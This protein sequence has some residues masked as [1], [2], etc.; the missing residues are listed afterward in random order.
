M[1]KTNQQCSPDRIS[2][3]PESIR[4]D[5]VSFL[6]MVDAIRTSIL[7]KS[8]R[9][10]C[11]SLSN[12][13][14][15]QQLF[16][17]MSGKKTSFKE[18]VNQ[19]IGCRDGSSINSFKLVVDV[20][21]STVP[22]IH[23][24]ISYVVQ[25]NV[26]KLH[27]C[28]KLN[29]GSLASL[30]CSLFACRTLTV[31]SLT[32]IHLELPAVVQF[33]LLKL[34]DLQLINWSD[35]EQTNRLISSCPLI[36][37]LSLVSCSWNKLSILVISAP[38][39][40]SLVLQ[41]IPPPEEVRISCPNLYEIQYT[42]PPPDISA[43][44]L[45]SL[46]CADLNLV[47]SWDKLNRLSETNIPRVTKIFM[48]MQNVVHL[49]LARFSLELL[50]GNLDLLSK[51]TT[52]SCS[53]KKLDLTVFSA[54][55]QVQFVASLLIIFPNL[56]ALT[57]RFRDEGPFILVLGEYCQPQK[58]SDLGALEII[59]IENLKGSDNELYLVQHFLENAKILS[60]LE[61]AYS[62][63]L[64]EDEPRRISIREKIFQFV[65]ASSVATISFM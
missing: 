37:R 58:S 17:E 52:S 32:A 46:L 7:S 50:S 62:I 31:L 8:W 24:W 63:E 16:E 34:L 10:V 40:K 65:K 14:F 56:Q 39:L 64:H 41:P 36:E 18:S 49:M 51:S 29:Y 2:N 59:I 45:S 25:H 42:G 5:I 4:N 47:P 12:L 30:P 60:K 57:I 54:K 55:R 3:L 53:T 9:N 23:A 1:K 27:L 61:I 15:D 26:Q 43:E 11:S 19:L 6:P 38:N 13:D 28:C 21:D 48:G 33:P 44:T 22:H 20:N 35:D